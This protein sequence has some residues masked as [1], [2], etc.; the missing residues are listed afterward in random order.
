MKSPI[1]AVMALSI[2]AACS[3][4]PTA[5]PDGP[6]AALV[7]NSMGW[8]LP[9][10]GAGAFNRSFPGQPCMEPLHRQFDFWVGEWNV[11]NQAETAQ[12]GTNI[13]LNLLDGCLVQ[14]NWTGGGGGR[15]RSL[16]TYDKET[17][18]WNQSWVTQFPGGHLRTRGSFDGTVM[19]LTDDRRRAGNL[20]LL[21]TWLWQELEPGKVQQTGILQAP[22][23]GFSNTF[24]GIYVLSDNVVPAPEFQSTACDAGQFAGQNR[25]GDFLVGSWTVMADDAQVGSSEIS[26]DLR[27]CMFEEQFSSGTGLESIAFMYFDPRDG[28]WHRIYVDS[29]GERV[30]LEGALV[31]NAIVLTG[32]EAHRS[33]T[34]DVRVTFAPGASG[35]TQTW[36]VSRDGGSTWETVLTMEYAPA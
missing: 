2:L 26:T 31:G 32:T 8:D 34:V 36:E 23:I 12:V 20:V 30:E 14:E 1:A 22:A 3:D 33:G 9:V 16:N 17:G 6:D 27:G 35:P 18:L 13:I 24:V 5:V 28:L 10:Y 29:E 7:G 11:F 19:R 4:E 25:A 21:D 15:G